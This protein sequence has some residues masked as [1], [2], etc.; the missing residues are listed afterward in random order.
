M[1]DSFKQE[2]LPSKV[3]E[4]LTLSFF[5]SKDYDYRSKNNFLKC[6]GIIYH[7]QINDLYGV[8]GYVPLGSAYWKR[9]YGGN[10]Y[11]QVILPLLEQGIIQSHD[12]NCRV[13]TIENDD[14]SSE[15][16]PSGEVSIRYRI[17]P[18]LTEGTCEIV[19]YITKGKVVTAEELLFNG[20]QEFENVKIKDK[21]FHIGIMRE[22]AIAYVKANA[23]RICYGYL[24]P[25]YIDHLPVNFSIQYHE[26]EDYNGGITFK[27]KYSTVIK[28]KGIALGKEKQLFYFHN[29]FYIADIESFIKHRA[30]ALRYYY[31]REISKID[32]L[33]IINN[34]SKTTLRLYNY[35]VNF[36]SKI[37]PYITINNK[38]IYQSDLSTSQFLLFANILNIYTLNGEDKL[39]E[40]FH[41]KITQDYLKKLCKILKAYTKQLPSI[42]VDITNPKL[43]EYGTS[44]VT[45][46]IRDVF[47]ADF[48]SIVQ[49]ELEL[50][51]R[52]MAKQT[53]F[54]LLFKKDSKSDKQIK[55]LKDRYRTVMSIIAD[56][57]AVEKKA[58]PKDTITHKPNQES[59]FSVFLQCVEAEIFIDNILIPLRVNGIPCFTRHD[60]ICVANG[61]EEATETHVK[62]VFSRFGFRYNHKKEDMFWLVANQDDMDDSGYSD[63]LA[64]EELMNTDYDIEGSYANNPNIITDNNEDMEDNDGYVDE[65]EME[66]LEKLE[67]Y[68]LRDNYSEVIDKALLEELSGLMLL[69][70]NQRNYLVQELENIRTGMSYFQPETNKVLRNLIFLYQ[71]Y[72]N[73]NPELFG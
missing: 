27:S 59:N 30:E 55:K 54:K 28:A 49:K 24:K 35:L 58:K 44:D 39:L 15:V 17:N 61:Y 26:F 47:F 29:K 50:P 56:F 62:E 72:R 8:N 4:A 25:D 70:D 67:E 11:T 3:I 20:G 53:L 22:E 45:K 5:N 14:G 32:V 73:A 42:V 57:K 52:G 16:K 66:V 34:Q 46:F 7:W 6:V 63:W 18:D 9:V 10:Y 33:P 2:Y 43:S 51:D 69:T 64:D 48:Y 23:E 1:S 41:E 71:R 60:S 65:D 37:L 13:I 21:D 68:G 40:L 12:F 19:K 31:L 36:P 38:T